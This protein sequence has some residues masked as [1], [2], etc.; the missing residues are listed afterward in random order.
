MAK[1]FL[2]G[3]EVNVTDAYVLDNAT[4]YQALKDL[5]QRATVLDRLIQQLGPLQD[6]EVYDPKHRKSVIRKDRRL[7]CRTV[8][9]ALSP[10]YPEKN[11]FILLT[12][13][14]SKKFTQL[15]MRHAGI[16]GVPSEHCKNTKN[17][18][19]R[20]EVCDASDP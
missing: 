14:R 1:C 6:T 16:S 19:N 10:S 9:D 15:E 17:F 2:T 8:A 3:I 11:L 7:V 20:K 5:R 13:Y 12:D 18:Q 4:A